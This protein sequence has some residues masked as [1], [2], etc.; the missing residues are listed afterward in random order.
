[1]KKNIFKNIYLIIVL[2]MLLFVA[3]PTISAYASDYTEQS[4]TVSGEVVTL[5]SSVQA[6]K[7]PSD[8]ADVLFE[9]S[10][11]ESIY[12]VGEDNGWCEIFYKG[13]TAYVK[14]D[15]IGEESI[16]SSEA[17]GDILKEE[18]EDEFTQKQQFDITYVDSFHKQQVRDRNAMIWKIIIIVLVVAIIAISVV[19]TI[20]MKNKNNEAKDSNSDKEQGGSED[21]AQANS[22]NEES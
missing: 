15:Q 14:K 16:A 22:S 4:N 8:D 2:G 7:E 3:G 13:E 11:G 20:R 6:R 12:V 19:M 10:A 9:F 21:K 18:L 1:M 17:S 5:N